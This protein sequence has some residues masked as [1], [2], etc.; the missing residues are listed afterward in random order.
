[1]R[2]KPQF[3][4]YSP[5]KSKADTNYE[6]S[7]EGGRKI[8]SIGNDAAGNAL[9]KTEPTAMDWTVEPGGLEGCGGS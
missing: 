5:P 9:A 7:V 6:F 2:S 4:D 3:R 8:T 1:M